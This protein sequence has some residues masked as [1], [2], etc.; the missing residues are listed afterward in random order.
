MLNL[1]LLLEE[2]ICFK[3]KNFILFHIDSK[4]LFFLPSKNNFIKM[5]Y[6]IYWSNNSIKFQSLN[7]KPGYKHN[8]S[9]QQNAGRQHNL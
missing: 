4:Y 9:L 2:N 8:S 1:A 5:F 7:W 3:M 6:K